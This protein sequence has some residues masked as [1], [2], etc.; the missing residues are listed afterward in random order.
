MKKFKKILSNNREL[1]LDILNESDVIRSQSSSYSH[2]IEEIGY[3][4][5]KEIEEKKWFP[6]K[7][8]T[9]LKNLKS[10]IREEIQ[11]ERIKIREKS[12]EYFLD[13]L[14]GND[15]NIYKSKIKELVDTLNSKYK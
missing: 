11:D 12:H 10:G 7:M 2:R 3:R 5:Y 13:A 4:L 14:E 8:A 9:P 1:H 15:I 6:E